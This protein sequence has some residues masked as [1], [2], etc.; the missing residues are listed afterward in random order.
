VIESTTPD[1]DP[2]EGILNDCVK[3]PKA[4]PTKTL[5]KMSEQAVS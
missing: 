3:L 2:P 4:K 1:C 5:C